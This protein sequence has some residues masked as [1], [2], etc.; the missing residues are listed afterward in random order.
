MSDK[1]NKHG[2]SDS[3]KRDRSGQGRSE[4][5]RTSSKEIRQQGPRPKPGQG[6]GT[7]GG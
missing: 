1:R 6:K 3:A 2:S 7:K 4:K 5:P